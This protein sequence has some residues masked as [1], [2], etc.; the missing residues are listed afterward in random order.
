MGKKFTL[1]A[2]EGAFTGD[3][4][5]NN[6]ATTP[7]P[8]NKKIADATKIAEE[9]DRY[10]DFGFLKIKSSAYEKTSESGEYGIERA[11]LHDLLSSTS[12][13]LDHQQNAALSF[14]REL[15]G[16]GLLADVVGSG[17]TF[18]ACTILSELAARGKI[19][20]MLLVVPEQTYE[21]WRDV[22]ELKFGLG[23][24]TI[25]QF[26]D[27][28]L[29][30]DI[31]DFYVGEKILKRPNLPVIVKTEDFAK[32]DIEIVKNILFDVIV[33]DE[34][35]HLCVEGG[36]YA[37]A[38]KLLS[39]MMITK[40][41]ANST[42]CILLSATPHSGNLT[43][44]FRLWYFIRCKGGEPSDFDDKDDKARTYKYNSEKQYYINTVCR[45]AST[46]AE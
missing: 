41:L 36:E 40:K 10:D 24:G 18:E 42:Y 31:T 3:A 37:K 14:L 46:V 9:L 32:W 27:K 35:H 43:N 38:L 16:F 15:R 21:M 2:A 4:T 5:L 19:N 8:F 1:R 44:M 25:A 29:F 33:V 26:D 39:A 30:K 20:S 11:H 34:A 22:L 12:V 45:G 6:I 17:K 28:P 13:I 23:K 7:E